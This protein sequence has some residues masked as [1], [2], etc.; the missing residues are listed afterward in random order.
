MHET[1]V[2]YKIYLNKNFNAYE[3]HCNNIISVS[4]KLKVGQNVHFDPLPNIPELPILP[5]VEIH[6]L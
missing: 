4:L 1:Q 3:T 5:P 6:K 2:M